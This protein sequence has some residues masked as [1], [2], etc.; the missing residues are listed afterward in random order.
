MDRHGTMLVTLVRKKLLLFL[1]SGDIMFDEYGD[2]LPYVGLG[3]LKLYTDL[4]GLKEMIEQ[5]KLIFSEPFLRYD[6]QHFVSMFFLPQNQKLFRLMTLENY[7]GMVWGKISTSTLE[8]ELTEIEPSFQ[9]D[10]M[11][12]VY[13]SPKCIFLQTHPITKR[14]IWISTYIRELYEP[15]FFEGKW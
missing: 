4:C 15:S 8:T 7:K 2:I 3:G 9:Y 10:P 11:E 12:E 1:L 13:E 6:Y 14:C 5:S